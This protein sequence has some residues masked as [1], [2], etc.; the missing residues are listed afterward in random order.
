ML[1]LLLPAGF[2]NCFQ[3]STRQA[4]LPPAQ[5]KAAFR[6]FSTCDGYRT[7]PTPSSL[8]RNDSHLYYSKCLTLHD[9]LSNT[10]AIDWGRGIASLLVSSAVYPRVK[11]E[12][13]SP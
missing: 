8:C 11:H 6:R 1:S 2:A 4:T 10:S 5:G 13:Y 12:Y 3:R 9:P 7:S